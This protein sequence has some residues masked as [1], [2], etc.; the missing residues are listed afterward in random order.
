MMKVLTLFDLPSDHFCTFAQAIFTNTV[1]EEPHRHDF[2]EFFW[3]EEGEGVHWLNGQPVETRPGDLFLIRAP[4]V[5]TFSVHAEGQRQ[6]LVNF[7]FFTR[8]WTH[9]RQRYFKGAP[10]FFSSPAHA[11]RRYKLDPDQLAAIRLAAGPLRS[12]LR[13]R[14]Q[15]ETF[16]L[17][18][19]ALL[20]A[21]RFHAEAKAAPDWIREA[22]TAVG[23]N[24]NFAGGMPAL[25]RLAGRSPEH[26][27]REFRRHLD[28]TPTAVINNARMSYAADRLATSDE[29]IVGI[30]LDCGL[31]NLGHFYRLFRNRYGCTPRIYRLQQRTVAQPRWSRTTA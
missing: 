4:D 30:A 19:L 14:L 3:V 7:A 1:L 29:G 27:A 22:C 11:S 6:R 28:C 20:S 2:H 23:A 10:V 9:V 24:R 8:V 18:V 13:D 12:G 16:L 31:E 25:S 15:T 26:I 21:D 5:H 17:S